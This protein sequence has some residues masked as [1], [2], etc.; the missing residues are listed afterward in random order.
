MK[1]SMYVKYSLRSLW[2]ERQRSIL[3]ISCIAVGVMAIVSMQLVGFMINA[4]FTT[5]IRDLNGGDIVVNSQVTPFSQH[6]LSFFDQLKSD[7]TIVNYTASY[8]FYGTLLL[9]G[10]GKNLFSI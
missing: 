5:D 1:V 8:N 9:G 4:A 6:D 7:R 2:R 10:K 3:A